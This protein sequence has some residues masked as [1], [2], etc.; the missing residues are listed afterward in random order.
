MS[1]AK[2]SVWTAA[3]TLVKIGVGLLVV[4][5][6]AASFGPQGVGQAANF[7]TMVTVLGVLSGA[8]IFNGVTKYVAEFQHDP[9]RLRSLLGT[10]SAITLLSSSLLA[11]VFVLGA[12]PIS[13]ILFGHSDFVPVIRAVGL[14]Q[15][16]IAYANLLLAILKGQ[17]DA[18]GNALALIAGSVIGVVAYCLSFWL[19]GYAGALAGMALVPAITVIPAALVIK[20]RNSVPFA[21][22]RP[23][24]DRPLA[25]QLLKFIVMV[26]ITSVTLPAAYVMLRN[27]LAADYGLDAVGMWQG[28]SKISDAY[29][30]FITASFSV[31][32][33]PTL[34]RLQQRDEIVR[35]IGRT[36]RFV[37]PAV[38]TVSF[39]VYLL[40]DVAIWLLFSPEFRPMR[41]LFAWQLTGDVFKV[42]AYVFGY[43]VVAKAA[44]RYYLL[45]EVSQFVLLT[46]LAHWLIPRSGALG[47]AQAYMLTYIVYF[48]LC[49]GAFLI[50]RKRA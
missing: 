30:Q 12:S 32:L 25:R 11:L 42:G 47:A 1:L 48:C 2:A 15:M 8:G 45:A 19:G 31:Y 41:D 9:Q 50:Y 35:E 5:L 28:V 20:K 43:L 13:Q 4:K 6:L 26:V 40:R 36:L 17:R 21:F 7:M 38:A 24:W 39:A 29:L 22:L 33:L 49:V 18:M 16:G 46:G 34:S 44:L 10:A 37:L 14:I 27:V 23:H 3:S